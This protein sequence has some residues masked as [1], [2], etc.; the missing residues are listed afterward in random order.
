MKTKHTSGILSAES[1]DPKAE[2]LCQRCAQLFSRF[3]IKS[4]NMDDLAKSLACSKKTLYK[5]FS[6]KRDLVTRSLG[7]HM[8][9]LEGQMTDL[10]QAE[11]NAIDQALEDME[12]KHAMLSAMNPSVLFDL[13][14]YY[15]KVFESTL[16]RRQAMVRTMLV[17]NVQRGM[18]EGLYRQDLNIDAV[19]DMHIALV[20]DM[21]RQAQD[22][23]LQRPLA[24]HFQAL[25]QYHIRGIASPR[26]LD[27]LESKLHPHP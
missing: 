25:F 13:K 12:K 8:D 10:L 7:A 9:L 18:G 27:F 15:P 26:G 14:K 11:G 20:E 17:H 23:T 5:Y 16:M 24:E 3:G 4:L 19:A 2:E 6:D 1:T 21:V 22:G